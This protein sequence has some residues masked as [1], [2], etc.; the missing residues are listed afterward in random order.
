MIES[1]EGIT[2]DGTRLSDLVGDSDKEYIVVNYVGG[3][4]LPTADYQ[5]TEIRSGRE[6]FTEFGAS[7]REIYAD[8]TIKGR[9]FADLRRI[10]D[11]L[12]SV[13]Y[14]HDDVEIAFDDEPGRA[15]F[16]R[17]VDMDENLEKS[18]IAQ[19]RIYFLCLDRDKYGAEHTYNLSPTIAYEGTHE[20]YPIFD[21]EVTETTPIISIKNLS[22]LDERE[23]PRSILLGTETEADEEPVE[24][25]TLALHDTMRSTSGWTGASDV[26]SGYDSG[27][28]AVDDEGCYAESWGDDDAEGQQA[29]WIGPS[30]QRSLPSPL[31]SF[32]TEIDITNLNFRDFEGNEHNNRVGIIEVYFRDINGNKVAKF[33]FG[34]TSDVIASNRFSFET[35]GKRKELPM[36]SPSAFNDF[37]G[38]VKIVRDS[39]YFY[40]SITWKNEDGIRMYWHEIG[41]TIPGGG[42]L[43]SNDVASIQVAIRKWIG[44][45]RTLRARIKEIK[46]WDYRGEFEYPDR[47]IVEEFEPGD[48]IHVNTRTGLVMVN[49]EERID[50]Q[51]LAS[52]MFTFVPGINRLEFS[53][54]LNGTVTYTDRYL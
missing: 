39:G 25:K 8:L 13:L 47:V 21:L 14:R 46:V 4:S 42:T 18:H 54:G 31:K 35:S 28:I 12:G 51:H 26:D 29:V 32:I 27:Q 52:R 43:G 53:D 38:Q 10:I 1:I 24:R 15:Y 22:N 11:R 16:G 40:P 44:A 20:T 34:D 36:S 23:N 30:L 5:T 17:Y 48:K 19:V 2:Y 33:Q 41:R 37:T 6:Y 45:K 7:P 50:L 9:S 3:R 49:G